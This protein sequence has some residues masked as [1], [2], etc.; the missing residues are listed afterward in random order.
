MTWLASKDCE[1]LRTW[2]RKNRVPML[3]SAAD[4]RIH[5]TNES[6]ENLLGYNEYEL[7]SGKKWTDISVND[8]SLEADERMVD[9]LVSGRRDEFS[10]RKQYLPKNSSPVWVEIHVM[11]WPT[12]GSVDC[13]LVTVVPLKDGSQAV[14]EIAMDAIAD[15]KKE[16]EIIKV[17]FNQSLSKLTDSEIV[18]GA[19]ARVINRYPRAAAIT[20]MVML[21]MLLGSQLVQ[22]V[23]ATK[24]MMG[25][26]IDTVKIKAPAE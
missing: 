12:G 7:T 14:A 25:F 1:M 24:R 11:R 17:L 21:V 13:F 26:Q 6:F 23:E 22:A 20:C 4:G 8:S 15:L 9:E 2:A 3:A 16:L 10:V 19:I 5:W 18:A